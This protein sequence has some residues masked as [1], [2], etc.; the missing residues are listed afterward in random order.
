[1]EAARCQ[2]RIPVSAAQVFAALCQSFRQ[3][4]K[5]ADEVVPPQIIS[6][7]GWRF[8][9]LIASKQGVCYCTVSFF[10]LR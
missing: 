8:I 1:M 5:D 3:K 2:V 10:P 9:Y 7:S 4:A 6:L